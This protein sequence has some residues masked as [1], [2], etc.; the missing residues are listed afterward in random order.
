MVLNSKQQQDKNKKQIPNFLFFVVVNIN[1]TM[2][3]VFKLK[4]LVRTTTYPLCLYPIRFS[5]SVLSQPPNPF[6]LPPPNM[7]TPPP[8]PHHP[9]RPTLPPFPGPPPSGNN[10]PPPP[11]WTVGFDDISSKMKIIVFAL[12]TTTTTRTF[13]SNRST[14]TANTYSTSS[15]TTCNCD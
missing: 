7:L 2:H 12:A 4:K 13:I 6:H 5:F 11:P 9:S 1:T 15:T 3:F 8:M 10:G 14:S